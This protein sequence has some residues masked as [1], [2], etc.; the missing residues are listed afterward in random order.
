MSGG[1][2]KYYQHL[3]RN[4]LHE[5]AVSCSFV[6]KLVPFQSSFN[7][8]LPT[9]QGF[10]PF[11]LRSPFPTVLVQH[12]CSPTKKF[13]LDLLAHQ[14]C[15]VFYGRCWGSWTCWRK[16]QHRARSSCPCLHS[17]PKWSNSRRRGCGKTA[18]KARRDDVVDH[19]PCP[20]RSQTLLRLY[21][22]QVLC[23]LLCAIFVFG[24]FAKAST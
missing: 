10:S 23:Y 2:T 15:C 17:T 24:F 11:C 8:I 5:A 20:L 6:V 21:S 1:R 22:L 12:L 3:L 4:L 13:L 19:L 18:Q 14:R 9:Q 16:K 7:V